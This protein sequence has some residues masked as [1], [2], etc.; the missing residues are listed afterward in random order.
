V[1]DSTSAQA[2][3]LPLASSRQVGDLPDYAQ[4][5]FKLLY[6]PVRIWA[7]EVKNPWNITDNHIVALLVPLWNHF[8]GMWESVHPVHRQIARNIVRLLLCSLYYNNLIDFLPVEAANSRVEEPTSLHCSQTRHSIHEQS[9][10][11]RRD[12]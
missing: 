8:I 6:A 9:R 7:G 2:A 1:H 5:D 3:V 10:T 4:A 11:R 12:L